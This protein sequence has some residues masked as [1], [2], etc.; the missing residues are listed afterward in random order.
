MMKKTF[1]RMVAGVLAA[2]M[3]IM[4]INIMADETSGMFETTK[5]VAL[6]Q[7]AALMEMFGV[8][9]VTMALV[10]VDS[11]FTWTQGLGYAYAAG[12]VAVTE[13]T[14][15]PIASSAKVFTAVAVMQLVEAGLLDLDEPIITYLPEFSVLPNP[16]YGGDYRNITTRMLLTHTSG[17]HEALGD[18]FVNIYGGP[19]RYIMNS[20]LPFLASQH[21]QNE[22]INRIT[23]NNTGY[24]LLGILVARLSGAENY[25]DG[26]VNFAQENIFNPAG[27][28]SS[29]FDIT[30]YNRP[31]IA[32]PH[33]DAETASEFFLYIG[34]TPAG[35][36]VSNAVDMARFMHIMLNG[37]IYGN[38]E[39]TRILQ[40]STIE[41]MLPVE[42]F[43]INFPTS[44]PT[45]MEMGLGFM[46]LS[47]SNG[48]IST[49]HG[50][51]LLHHTEM[52]IDFENGI[53]VFVSV[54]AIAGGAVPGLIGE[55]IWKAAVYEKT[56]VEVP[57]NAYFGTPFVAENLEELV[58]W[59]ATA[60]ELRL[61]QDGVLYFPSPLGLPIAVAY[62]CW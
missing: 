59:Y 17:L 13:H 34:G 32:L 48:A 27:M 51:N 38:D 21:M 58:G 6:E 33:Y 40:P 4:P 61:N 9:G 7:T 10:D 50:G 26:F 30:P 47:R 1:K 15:F 5:Q 52:I 41:A 28:S 42:N 25:F 46:H 44:A 3:M 14:L 55:A 31:Y 20:M 36:M 49:G 8:P 62:A 35:G 53:G 24:I 11:G 16:L 29:S 12:G 56:G 43:G 19:N 57:L 18:Y 23:Y 2:T 54:N 45:G 60:G 37:G 22:E 39:S